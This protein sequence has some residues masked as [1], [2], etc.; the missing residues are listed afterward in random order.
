MIN[1][2]HPWVAAY[3]TQEATDPPRWKCKNGKSMFAGILHGWQQ[4]NGAPRLPIDDE[5]RCG[6]TAVYQKFESGI[7]LYDPDKEFDAP[8]GPWAPCYLLKLDSPLAKQ[9][10]GTEGQAPID[11]TKLTSD[12]TNAA[13]AI[14]EAQ[15]LLKHPSLG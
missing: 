5:V 7:I 1:I 10:L 15:R 14:A 3:F 13:A 11:S 8:S 6:K 12:L 4:M 9:L 2:S